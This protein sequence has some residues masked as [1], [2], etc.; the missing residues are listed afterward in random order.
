MGIFMGDVSGKNTPFTIA[1][2]TG[3]GLRIKGH[4]ATYLDD[5]YVTLAIT[6]G[7][8]RIGSFNTDILS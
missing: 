3:N 7:T 8:A 4:I 6:K 2:G 1:P 5:T